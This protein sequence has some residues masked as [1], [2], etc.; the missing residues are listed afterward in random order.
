MADLPNLGVGLAYRPEIHDQVV[1]NAASVDWLEVMTESFLDRQR[2]L[3]VLR[4]LTGGKTIVLHGVELSIGSDSP[5]DEDYVDAVAR[6][7]DAIDA[8]WVSDH[9]CFTREGDIDIGNLTPVVRTRERARRMAR[10]ARH[11][12]ERIGRPLLLENITYYVDLPGELSEPELIHEVLADADCAMLLD[13]HNVAVNAHNHGFDPEAYI[14]ALPLDRVI[15]L[16]LAGNSPEAELDG[17]WI[18]GHDGPIGNDLLNLLAFVLE[19]VEPRGILIERD[20]NFPEDFGELIAELDKVRSVVA[21]G[22]R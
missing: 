14:A 21:A 22:R 12:Q 6:L 8:P 4:E 19:R 18:D 20:L 10:R 16:H 7:A 15:Q 2:Y 3:Q 9:L 13:L 5:L 17:V 11:V 1:A